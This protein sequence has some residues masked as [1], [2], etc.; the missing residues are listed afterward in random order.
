MRQAKTTRI[1][2]ET[3]IQAELILDSTK[4]SNIQTGIGFFDHMLTLFAF[5]SGFQ[6]N[7]KAEGDL[8]VCDHHTVE[9]IGI[10]LGDLFMEALGDKKGIQR[11]GNFFLPMDETLAQVSIDISG[12][13]YLVY[14]CTLKRDSIGTF[15]C[16]MVSEFLRAF[17]HHAML[18]LHVNVLYGENDHHKIEAIFKALGRSLAQ[19]S[20]ITSDALPSSKGVL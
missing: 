3:K 8:D 19:A 9:D 5:H 16:E 17:A 18:T 20:A 4:D 10:V 1:T 2:K 15:S 11:Y 12:R 7:L 14:N 13:S 6:L